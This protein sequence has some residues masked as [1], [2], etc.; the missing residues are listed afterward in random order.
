M[1]NIFFSAYARILFHRLI[2]SG[3]KIVL[4]RMRAHPLEAFITDNGLGQG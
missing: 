4:F 2:E 1:W 3:L